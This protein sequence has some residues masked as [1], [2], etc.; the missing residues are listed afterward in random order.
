MLV[1]FGGV[2][3]PVIH[4]PSAIKNV[5]FAVFVVTGE[6]GGD[7]FPVGVDK[8]RGS[9]GGGDCSENREPAVFPDK[10]VLVVNVDDDDAEN[11]IR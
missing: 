4:P 2:V 11:I 6:N 9:L 5:K 7:F 10:V 1:K 3:A 8:G